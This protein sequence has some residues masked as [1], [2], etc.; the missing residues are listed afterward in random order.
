ML[1]VLS[2]SAQLAQRRRGSARIAILDIEGT[3]G[4]LRRSSDPGY[5]VLKCRTE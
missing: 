4:G 2:V 5:P 3:Q 1:I